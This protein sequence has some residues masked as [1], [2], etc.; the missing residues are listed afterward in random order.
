MVLYDVLH[1]MMTG[2]MWTLRD[3]PGSSRYNGDRCIVYSTPTSIG[4]S[5][6][7]NNEAF[8]GQVSPMY[9]G[10]LLFPFSFPGKIRMYLSFM[11]ENMIYASNVVG[12]L[13]SCTI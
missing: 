3:P 12:P 13:A 9:I 4:I 1:M 8:S 7:A 5:F 2:F 11:Q 6:V 10:I